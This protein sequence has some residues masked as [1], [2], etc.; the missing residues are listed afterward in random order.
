MDNDLIYIA[1]D[2]LFA[3]RMALYGGFNRFPN[4]EKIAKNGTL[5]TNAVAAAAST[6]MCHASEWTGRPTWNLHPGTPFN[7]RLFTTEMP[8][9]D[10][11]F[12]DFIEMGFDV[13]LVM[14]KQ[15]GRCFDGYSNLKNIWP[16]EIKIHTI[17]NSTEVGGE[18]NNRRVQFEKIC[19]VIEESR[20]EGR[21]SFVWAKCHGFEEENDLINFRRYAGQQRVTMDDLFCS[22]IDD[23]IGV[24]LDR[25]SFPSSDCPEVVFGSDHGAWQGELRR[26]KYGFHLDQEILHVPLVSSKGD[27]RVVS[28]VFS[29]KELRRILSGNNPEMN[30]RFV[31]SET[32]FP[33]QWVDKP[34]NGASSMGSIMVRLNRWKYIYCLN[35]PEGTKS[36]PSEML[37]DLAYDPR[38]KCDLIEIMTKKHIDT[39]R[40]GHGTGEVIM[41]TVSRINSNLQIV[42]D[43]TEY[44]PEGFNF[45]SGLYHSGWSEVHR[46][47]MKLRSRVKSILSDTG[48][49]ELFKY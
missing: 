38:E 26:A 39:A 23:A 36:S 30:E 28:S 5:Y 34:Y 18:T 13:H 2:R 12:S 42:D 14:V 25:F 27:G 9:M 4:I 7:E 29:M 44:S 46:V 20:S 19:E 47:W 35:G 31:Y 15:E 40:P 22:A 45:P 37:Y 11:V 10:S 1:G 48:R 6:L 43:D 32:L 8:H 49:N 16:D 24:I 21:R 17:L 41:N 3:G 33:G